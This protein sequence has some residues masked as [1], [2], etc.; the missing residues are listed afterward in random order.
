LLLHVITAAAIAVESLV[1]ESEVAMESLVFS[2]PGGTTVGVEGLSNESS[3]KD[4]VV[5]SITSVETGA[6]CF[7]LVESCVL[8]SELWSGSWQTTES[9]P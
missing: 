3:V 2:S 6:G 9:K 8:S 7:P 4:V 5:S 1:A